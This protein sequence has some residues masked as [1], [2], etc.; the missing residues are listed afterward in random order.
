QV[1]IGCPAEPRTD[2]VDVLVGA[3]AR[4]DDAGRAGAQLLALTGHRD[5]PVVV[6]PDVGGHDR[7]RHASHTPSW[8][9]APLRTERMRF[10]LFPDAGPSL[11]RSGVPERPDAELPVGL[12]RYLTR[13]R[14]TSHK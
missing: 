7:I 2:V 14:V 9:F 10:P 5:R 8:L 4:R 13:R 12:Y 1:G 3:V 11:T 6:L